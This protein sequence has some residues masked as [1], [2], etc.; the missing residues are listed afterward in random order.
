LMF[1]GSET[2]SVSSV[3]LLSLLFWMLTEMLAALGFALVPALDGDTFAVMV[4]EGA[5][6]WASAT[7]AKATELTATTAAMSNLRKGFSSWD[8]G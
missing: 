1:F 2:V 6:S 5:G 4:T 3:V 8:R 7:A